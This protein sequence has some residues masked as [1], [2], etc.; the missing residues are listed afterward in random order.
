MGRGRAALCRRREGL[1]PSVIGSRENRAAAASACC[2]CHVIGSDAKTARR[3]GRRD[4]IS[5]PLFGKRRGRL[6][7]R[8]TTTLAHYIPHGA[9]KVA[10]DDE[11]K[12][13]TRV[14]ERQLTNAFLIG[15]VNDTG[16]RNCS[17]VSVTHI[18]YKNIEI[19]SNVLPRLPR[20]I[21]DPQT[22]PVVTHITHASTPAAFTS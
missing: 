7:T 20:E 8:Q 6:A 2:P 19:R 10:A 4:V 13:K 21:S 12:K 22:H 1:R 17:Y 9:T 5:P 11:E 14:Q 16:L 15:P 3:S 18:R